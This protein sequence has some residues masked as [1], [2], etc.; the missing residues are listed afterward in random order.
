MIEKCQF[1]MDLFLISLGGV[2]SLLEPKMMSVSSHHEIK[3]PIYK[4]LIEKKESINTNCMLEN[5]LKYL[6]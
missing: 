5:G 4:K 6:Y 2:D 3:T 1:S